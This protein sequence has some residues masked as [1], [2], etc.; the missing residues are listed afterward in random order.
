MFENYSYYIENYIGGHFELVRCTYCM[1]AKESLVY[2]DETGCR[3]VQTLFRSIFVIVNKEKLSVIIYRMLVNCIFV[4]SSRSHL[5]TFLFSVWQFCPLPNAKCWKLWN[6]YSCNLIEPNNNALQTFIS[7]TINYLHSAIV[8]ET[9]NSHKT[10]H[11]IQPL[12]KL[13]NVNII[14]WKNTFCFK[15]RRSYLFSRYME[16]SSFPRVFPLHFFIFT[17]L[18]E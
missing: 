4:S 13:F 14:Q 12:I 18:T 7:N 1:Q 10:V 11:I 5:V 15:C 3:V 17:Y 9:R 2:Y 8:V 6:R 16:I